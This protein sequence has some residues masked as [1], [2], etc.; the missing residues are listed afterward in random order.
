[1]LRR[2]GWRK[3]LAGGALLAVLFAGFAAWDL[4]QDRLRDE[5]MAQFV[6]RLDVQP[7]TDGM[8]AMLAELRA[9]EE[10]SRLRSWAKAVRDEYRLWRDIPD[11]AGAVQHLRIAARLMNTGETEDAIAI[12]EKVDR[13]ALDSGAPREMTDTVEDSLAIAYLRLGEQQNCFNNPHAGACIVPIDRGAQHRLEEGSTMAIA[14]LEDR[15]LAGRPDDYKSKWLLN[16]A[17][18]TLG[19]YPGDVPAEH[20]L[21]MPGA[22]EGYAG[23]KFANVSDLA[24][25]DR[26]NNAGAAVVEDFDGDG[27]FDVFTTSWTLDGEVILYLRA[28]DGRLVDATEQSGLGGLPGGLNAI[29]GDF[30]NDGDAD[31]YLMRGAWGQGG[32]LLPNSLLRNDGKGNFEDA[33]VELGL[34]Q[35]EPTLSSTFA[36]LD[37]D[38]W[39]D[40]VVAN[41]KKSRRVAG[42]IDIFMNRGGKGFE[43][44]PEWTP[45]GF[46]CNPKSVAAGDYDGDGFADL[47][48]SCLRQ[49]NVLFRNSGALAFE[50]VTGE[51]GV[52][53]PQRSFASWF[54]D[55]DNDGWQDLFVAGYGAGDVTGNMARSFAGRDASELD[56]KVSGAAL[57]RNRGDGTFA[58]VTAAAGLTAPSYVMG[59]AYGDFDND[60]WLDMY[61]GTGASAYDAIIP[62][63]AMWN[64]QGARFEEI[65]ASSGL[66]HIQ[67]GH[68]IAF[69]D[70]DRDGDA[71]IFAQL[72]GSAAGDTFMNALFE[73]LGGANRWISLRLEGRQSN[74]GAVGAVIRVDV[75]DD[76]GRQF[77]IW[78]AVGTGGSFGSSP[79][80]QHIGLGAAKR[81]ERVT[82]RWPASGAEQTFTRVQ[83]DK[84]YQLVE[85]RNRLEPLDRRPAP[86]KRLPQ[87]TEHADH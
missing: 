40:L 67:K 48:V 57:Y 85:G 8:K 21:P 35:F 52:G 13:W 38:G 71:D 25:V 84:A 86:F 50:D 26:R 47:H 28:P 22:I 70:F 68:G 39:L 81:I 11:A 49:A 17:H 60:G 6:E 43:R 58:D 41:E 30:D 29:H 15:V 36:D 54:F 5:P 53:G 23:P 27:Q 12:L 32:G 78:R 14:V 75:T 74:R 19:G 46:D 59:S 3:I 83:S 9:R 42:R 77:A 45:A 79:L 24:A 73:N 72:G 63:T 56:D 64:R 2:I 10:S 34:L 16:I 37:N 82:V 51:A 4:Q 61:W 55:Y 20:L 44:L 31:I 66:G 7:G 33:T 65:T 1:M 87:R 69:A 62:N 18:M 76:A 80:E